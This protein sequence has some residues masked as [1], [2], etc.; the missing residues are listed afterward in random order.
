MWHWFIYHKLSYMWDLILS[1]IWD[2]TKRQLWSMRMLICLWGKMP[3]VRVYVE[4]GAHVPE[5]I[6][7]VSVT[8]LLTFCRHSDVVDV[9]SFVA[10]CTSISVSQHFILAHMD[11]TETLWHWSSTNLRSTSERAVAGC[12]RFLPVYRWYTLLYC[13][14]H[15]MITINLWYLFP[16]ISFSYDNY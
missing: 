9:V 4:Q 2:V 1:H 5:R 13:V 10:C 12:V 8:S 3:L 16:M 11:T 15:L 7:L 14:V 6:I